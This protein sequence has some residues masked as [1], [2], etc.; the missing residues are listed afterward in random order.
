MAKQP[1]RQGDILL[2]PVDQ[3]PPWAVSVKRSRG[4]GIVVA[5]GEATGHHHRVMDRHSHEFL[6][7]GSRERFLRV[8]KNGA[9]LTHE[10]HEPIEVPPGTYE[11]RQQ[12]EFAPPE[13]T[14]RVTPGR[15]DWEYVRD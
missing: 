6:A 7:I 2:V 12:R 10:E 8:S 4:Q 15:R 14:P 11:I 5:E 9:T 13:P 3:M 1:L